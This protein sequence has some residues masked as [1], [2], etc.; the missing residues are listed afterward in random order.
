VTVIYI[1][2]A[3]ATDVAPTDRVAGLSLAA[4]VF[5]SARR[6][7]C[8]RVIAWAPSQAEA[9]ASEAERVDGITV[10]IVRT[11]AE[12]QRMLDAGGSSESLATG[13]TVVTPGVVSSPGL[14]TRA[15]A[16][17]VN[18]VAFP[19]DG[20]LL[21][22]SAGE[23]WPATGV[24]RTT[25]ACARDV[26]RLL[27]QLNAVQC[28]RWPMPD[29][30]DIALKRAPLVARAAT[31]AEL[32]DVEQTVRRAMFKPNDTYL[33]RLN[34]RM[35]LPISVW[36]I[37]HTSLSANAL[38]IM[39]VALGFVAA[40]LFA[41]GAYVASVTGAL[42]SLAASILDGSDGEIARLTYEESAFGCWVETIGDYSY[43]LALFAGMTI[44][45]VRSTGQPLFAWIGAGAL[46]G[47]IVALALL[48]ILRRQATGGNPE[49]LQQATVIRF[50]AEGSWWTWLV[51]RISFVATRAVMPYGIA[52]LTI[53]NA[54]PLVVVL[55]CVGTN[56]Y[57]ISLAL[58]WPVLMPTGSSP[59][60]VVPARR[61][62]PR[63]HAAPAVSACPG[64]PGTAASGPHPPL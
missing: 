54:V 58:M 47:L 4:R 57:W 39:L 14:L 36:L 53:L 13:V 52:V 43:Y 59:T 28:A 6:A 56:V 35:S 24:Y 9:I 22:I 18:A 19:S 55:T 21:P 50:Y 8:D 15:E 61:R 16:L 25:M 51:A 29:G 11:T 20:R 34:R 1:A 32:P 64:A 62:S 23:G 27:E 5:R 38:S 44:G 31:R 12:W 10:Q 17:N 30:A 60:A 41:V 26:D 7:G 40:W 45:T 3:G 33:A 46:A 63:S 2:E 48:V 37:E 49:A 42:L